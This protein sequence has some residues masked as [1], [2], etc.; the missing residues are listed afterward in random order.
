MRAAL[1]WVNSVMN[2]LPT[3][4]IKRGAHAASYLAAWWTLFSLFAVFDWIDMR[5]YIGGPDSFIAL[6]IWA[7]HLFFIVLAVLAWKFEKPREVVWVETD[8]EIDEAVVESFEPAQEKRKLVRTIF[9][10]VVETVVILAGLWAWAGFPQLTANIYSGSWSVVQIV[11]I[12]AL[13]SIATAVTRYYQAYQQH[14]R[15]NQ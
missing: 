15:K 4:N 1:L 14:K 11:I 13:L 12:F 5:R 10:L 3:K 6:T 9:K 7:V 2:K 8:E